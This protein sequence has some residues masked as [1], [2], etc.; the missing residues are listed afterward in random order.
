MRV[1]TLQNCT[2]HGSVAVQ[3]WRSDS[4]SVPHMCSDCNGEKLLTSVTETKDIAKI[5]VAQ[6]F[7]NTVCMYMLCYVNSELVHCVQTAEKFS[8]LFTANC[9]P[10]N[11]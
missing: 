2:L 4:V 9:S 1:F 3:A 10:L 6:F 8:R 5:K 7:W 11:V